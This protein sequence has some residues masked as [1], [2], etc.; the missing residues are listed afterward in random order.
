MSQGDQ[1]TFQ[2]LWENSGTLKIHL[3][4]LELSRAWAMLY[5]RCHRSAGITSS[6]SLCFL[7]IRQVLPARLLG[8]D[9]PWSFMSHFFWTGESWLLQKSPAQRLTP[10]HYNVCNMEECNN[11][12][13]RDPRSHL[14]QCPTHSMANFKVLGQIVPVHSYCLKPVAF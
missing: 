2:S 6:D 13:E 10:I 8:C 3:G 9:T 4:Q 11:S 12:I 1:L 7:N 5:S 14:V